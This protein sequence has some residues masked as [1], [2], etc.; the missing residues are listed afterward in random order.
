M[1]SIVARARGGRR[2]GRV[3]R[4]AEADLVVGDDRR[5]VDADRH[6]VV[7]LA[8]P[9]RAVPAP[10]REEVS[11]DLVREDVVAPFADV[12][13][14][15]ESAAACSVVLEGADGGR[16]R[17]AV[18]VAGVALGDRAHGRV[19][20]REIDAREPVL[21]G[22][23]R[24]RGALAPQ[25]LGRRF[26]PPRVELIRIA[27]GRREHPLLVRRETETRS[28]AVVPRLVP[29]DEDDGV[30]PAD[31]DALEGPLPGDTVDPEETIPR[32]LALPPVIVVAVPRLL[33]S[34]APRA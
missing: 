15:V 22:K 4:H 32:P 28:F 25:E 23:V 24:R 30:V 20:R 5:L 33:A 16:P 9:P 8:R 34:R 1:A 12:A 18:L 6:E 7:H 10:A 31:L 11:F 21:V 17:V 14:H 3:A 27:S 2:S 26:V 29:G 13:P 19:R